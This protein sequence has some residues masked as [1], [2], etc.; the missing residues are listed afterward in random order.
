MWNHC[1]FCHFITELTIFM[2]AM[3]LNINIEPRVAKHPSRRLLTA[4][5]FSRK[6]SAIDK[7]HTA[8]TTCLLLWWNATTQPVKH[9]SLTL[10]SLDNKLQESVQII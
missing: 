6:L 10:V 7:D 1:T 3:R 2:S 8:G 4:Q 5:I 9:A